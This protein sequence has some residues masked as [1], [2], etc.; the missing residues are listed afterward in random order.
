MAKAQTKA[1][2]KPAGTA[3][4]AASA[5]QDMASQHGTGFENVTAT[6]IIIPR[7]GILQGLSPAV[8]RGDPLYNSEA[9]VGDIYDLGMQVKLEEPLKVIV[10]HYQK[11]Y[12]EWAP[13]GSGKGLVA[14]H[15]NPSVM[16][17]VERDER[18][19]PML[20]NG[21]TITETM[22]FFCILPD[23]D[24]KRC[25][26]PMSSTQFKKGKL[27]LSMALEE[28][29]TTSDG[30]EIVPPIFFREYVLS[31]VPESNNEGNWIGWKVERGEKVQDRED[32]TQLMG[33][34]GEFRSGVAAGTIKA[35][36]S[37]MDDRESKAF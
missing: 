13:R 6:D 12:I 22:Q 36:D 3:V 16:D 33:L 9:S 5:F 2:A 23:Y 37:D 10:A 4:E 17:D 15:D 25:F 11:Q 32:F 26:I 31:T 21:N 14:I 24:Y 35:D 34:V 8:T 28:K 27:L 20:P 18:N 19:R 1:V 7:V 30:R 29:M